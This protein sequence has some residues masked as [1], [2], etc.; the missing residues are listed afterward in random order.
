MSK[1]AEKELGA[2]LSVAVILHLGKVW[3]IIE[4]RAETVARRE[5]N[6]SLREVWVLLAASSVKPLTQKQIAKH[7]GLNQ[8]AMV[9]LLDKLERNGHVR[10]RRNPDNRREQFVRLTVKG[11][12]AVGALLENRTKHHRTILAP[13]GDDLIKTI[14]EAVQ[15]VLAFEATWDGKEGGRSSNPGKRAK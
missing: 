12:S 15:S 11:E 4:R 6:L 2:V 10:R 7:L 5:V 9:L 14:F 8:N 13:L 3:R 1:A